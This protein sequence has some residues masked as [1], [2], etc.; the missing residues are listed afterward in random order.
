VAGLGHPHSKV[1]LSLLA[2]LDALLAAGAASQTL[3]EA[4]V[5]PGVRA[6]AADRSPAVRE[7]FFVALPRWMGVPAGAGSSTSA[8]A[9]VSPAPGTTVDGASEVQPSSSGAGGDGGNDASPSE[10]EL[11]RCRRFAPLLLP[12]LL[13]GVSDPAEPIAAL[14]LAQVERV[15]EVWAAGS[16]SAAEASAAGVEAPEQQDSAAAMQV[17]GEAPRRTEDQQQRGELEAGTETSGLAVTAAGLPPPYT[18]LPGAGALAMG[19]AILPGLLPPLLRELG[20]WTVALRCTAARCLHALLVLAGPAATAQ[21]ARLLPGLTLAVGDEDAH[22]AGRVSACIRVIGALVPASHWLPLAVDAVA[23]GKAGPAARANALVTLSRLAHAGVRA[24]QA[25]DPRQLAAAGAALGCEEALMAAAAHAGARAQLLVAVRT[26]LEWAGAAAGAPEVAAPL[27]RSLLL[28]YGCAVVEGSAGV[29][30]AGAV[31]EALGQ[32]QAAVAAAVEV[33]DST[34]GGSDGGGLLCS[35]HGM[36][37]L[38]AL[39]EGAPGWTAGCPPLLAFGALLRTAPPACLAGLLPR[40]FDV[41]APLIA[42]HDGDPGLRLALLGLLDCLVEGEQTGRAFAAPDAAAAALTRLVMPPLTWRTGK[43]AAAVRFS[44]V[45]VL[46]GLVERRLADAG[47]LR[48]AVDAG[49][50]PLLHQVGGGGWSRGSL[51]ALAYRPSAS[52]RERPTWSFSPSFTSLAPNPTAIR[53]FCC[54]ALT[55]TGTPTYA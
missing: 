19:A 44:A 46:S 37:L 20:E 14:A 5:A 41:M 40:A 26:L 48:G 12:L 3:V 29:P 22:V 34:G 7:A 24:G 28:L 13:L 6:L 39:A 42:D 16:S 55:R 8:P 4:I 54:S 30:E 17:D 38:E 18:R 47:A 35:T 21:L 31:A 51:G 33:G 23:D 9:V 1:R 15:G 49:L 11:Q 36:Q 2:A 27:Y 32:L 53:P 25:L 10:G 45:R 43:V 50:L 52:R